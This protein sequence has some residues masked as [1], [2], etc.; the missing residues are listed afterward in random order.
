MST[1]DLIQT[2]LISVLLV[3]AAYYV[4]S[5]FFSRSNEPTIWRHAIRKGDVSKALI[6]LE[7]SYKDKDRFLNFWYQVNRLRKENID[8]AFAELGVYK[9]D[10]AQ[11][12]NEMDD[13]R[14]F[15]LFDTFEGFNQNV[16]DI[17]T[18][19]AATY[20]TYDFADTSYERVKQKLASD[21]F[22]FHVGHFPGT[23]K[24]MEEIKYALVNM[25]ADLY[26][27]TLAGLNYFYPRL[28]H[29]GVII[30]HDYK[31]EWPGIMKAVNEY[32]S[33]ISVPIV[34]L[35]D[36]DCSVMLFKEKII[37]S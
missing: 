10:S 20:N 36:L 14:E 24:N 32:A 19:K 23:T 27:P 11:V 33:K 26:N 13:S 9:G 3:Y 16:L 8:G 29:G 28:T 37:S 30:I 15:H 2:L 6:K 34:P 5:S 17:E 7:R 35:T 25:D 18:G 4:Y 12:L 31:P 21:N 22:K 1:Y